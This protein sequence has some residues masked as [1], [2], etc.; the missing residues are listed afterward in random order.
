MQERNYMVTT[1]QRTPL[2]NGLQMSKLRKKQKNE[3]IWHQGNLN[4]QK[5][6]Q[7]A[8]SQLS[9]LLMSEIKFLVNTLLDVLYIFDAISHQRTMN[10][11][12]KDRSH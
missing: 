4:R 10:S 7:V 8:A 1:N 11:N 12:G 5:Y 3:G 6:Q 2:S 9:C